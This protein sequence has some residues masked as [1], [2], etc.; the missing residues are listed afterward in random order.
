MQKYLS[1]NEMANLLPKYNLQ[2]FPHLII[3]CESHLNEISEKISYPC[4]IKAFSPEI[5]HKTKEG[6]VKA[7]ILSLEDLKK[8]YQ[9]LLNRLRQK[10]IKDFTVICQRQVSGSEFLIGC[11]FDNTFGYVAVF[12]LGGIFTEILNKAYLMI[13]PVS[14]KMA[15]GA[16]T[17]IAGQIIPEGA[18]KTKISRMIVAIAKMA[19]KE[20]IREIDLNPVIVDGN[21]V[22]LVDMRII[23]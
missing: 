14:A 20:K 10:K 22:F 8:N 19:K 3:N 17:E 16:V 13:S 4:V 18:A 21:D 5:V 15:N 7:G 23:K 9:I 2:L 12:G 6:F 11:K 1:L